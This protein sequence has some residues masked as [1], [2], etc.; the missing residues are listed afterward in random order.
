MLKRRVEFIGLQMSETVSG[1][2]YARNW[3]E[4]VDYLKSESVE[5]ALMGYAGFVPENFILPHSI[6]KVIVTRLGRDASEVLHEFNDW[7][8]ELIQNEDF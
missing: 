3:D 7:A 6:C 4:V 8:L 1:H 5:K 2:I